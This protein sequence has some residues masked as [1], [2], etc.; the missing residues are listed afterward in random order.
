MVAAAPR[1]GPTVRARVRRR[2]FSAFAVV[3]AVA[4]SLTLTSVPANAA[5]AAVSS[6]VSTVATSSLAAAKASPRAR[7]VVSKTRT[8]VATT[9]FPLTTTYRLP[10]LK[11]STAKNR[12]RV[13]KY[14]KAFLSAEKSM[15][16]KWRAGCATSPYPAEVRVTDVSASIYKKRYASVTMAFSSDAGCGGVTQQSARSF[17]IDLKTGKKAK[18]SKFVASTAGVNRLATLSALRTQNSDCVTGAVTAR[19]GSTSSLP[20]PDAWNVSPKGVRVWFNRYAIAAGA[21]GAVSALVP[22]TD[23]ATSAQL[24]GKRTSRVYVKDL[25]DHGDSFTGAIV[26]MTVQGKQ[27]ARFDGYLFSEAYCTLGVRTGKKVRAFDTESASRY[28]FNLSGTK[29]APK[30]RLGKGWRLATAKE[31]SRFRSMGVGTDAL[32]FCRL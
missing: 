11:G 30:L 7:L 27:V 9:P 22:W 8:T 12:S 3:T 10:V 20:A 28:V 29:G 31:L 1:S 4:G 16:R 2:R 17:T 18:L 26:G 32:K 5:S 19:R 15:A 23:V 14:A 21:C 24:K 6:P 13:Q 25:V